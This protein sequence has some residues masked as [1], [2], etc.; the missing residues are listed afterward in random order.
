MKIIGNRIEITRMRQGLSLQDLGDMVGISKS[1]VSAIEKGKSS[2]RPRTAKLLCDALGMEFD[3]LF[4]ISEREEV[5][6]ATD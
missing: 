1:S 4:T 3:E 2:P 6:N 5:R